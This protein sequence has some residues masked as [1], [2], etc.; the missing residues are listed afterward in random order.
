[1]GSHGYGYRQIEDEFEAAWTLKVLSNGLYLPCCCENGVFWLLVCPK[2]HITSEFRV[3][4][5][6]EAG[7]FV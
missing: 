2:A 4:E 7:S 5:V 6:S 3:N 1:M